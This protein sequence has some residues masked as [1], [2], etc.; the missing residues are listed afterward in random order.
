MLFDSRV[1]DAAGPL[2]VDR[3]VLAA[4]AVLARF[5][6]QQQQQHQ[7][8]LVSDDEAVLAVL[9]LH[10]IP[11]ALSPFP[12][13]VPL[14][15]PLLAASRLC[16][17]AAAD[18]AAAKA[19]LAASS[20]S[21]PAL[22]ATKVLGIDKLRRKYK[23]FEMRRKL[24]GSYDLFLCDAAI[25]PQLISVLGK[26]FFHK[27]KFPLA[28]DMTKDLS[29]QLSAAQNSTLLRQ[30]AGTTWVI[31]IG[32]TG[33][34]ARHLAENAVTAVNNAV[35]K[36]VAGKWTNIRAIHIK[37]DTSISLPVY[38]QLAPVGLQVEGASVP[39]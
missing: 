4:R 32:N 6:Q 13:P 20:S 28:I 2:D 33:W 19:S 1:S 9:S 39:T 38:E 12:L 23:P 8:Q 21:S 36:G 24:A 22:A 16:L 7:Q 15:H 10:R 37:S 26:S 3:V 17:L 25:Q 31:K 5:A 27:N 30:S 29:A 34:D 18:G 14:A 11:D 35:A